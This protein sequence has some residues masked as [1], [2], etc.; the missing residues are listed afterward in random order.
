MKFI[1]KKWKIISILVVVAFIVFFVFNNNNKEIKSAV[2]QKGKMSEE[3]ILSGEVNAINYA[4]LGYETSGK[5]SYVGVREG[6]NVKKGRLL[7]KLDTTVLNSSYQIALSNLRIYDATAQNILDQVKNHDKDETYAQKDL[8]TT[9]E[10]NK[11]KAYESMLQAKRNLDGAY[12]YAPFNGIVTFVAH[13][14]TSVF[15]SFGTTEIEIID[16]TTMYFSVLADQTEVTKVVNGQKVQIVLDSFEEKKFEGEVESISFV[17]KLG[18]SGSVYSIK[19]NFIGLNLLESKFKIAMT[20]DAKF[21]VL[22]KENV[23][24]VP[25]NYIKQDKTGEYLKTNSKDGKIYIKSGISSEDMTEII[26]DINKG[27]VVYD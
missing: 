10:A 13:P 5:I 27:M 17:P 7:T 9:A 11:D 18:E 23:L 21:V 12:I 15:V 20:G 16:P 24:F 8:R 22:E 6:E 25:S 2:I 1:R 26:G 3:I 14:F 19:V 4:K